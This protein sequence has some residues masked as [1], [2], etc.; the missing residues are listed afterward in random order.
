[1]ILTPEQAVEFGRELVSYYNEDYKNLV[2]VSD[3]N[4][5]L[6]ELKDENMQVA[7]NCASNKEAHR[8]F[9]SFIPEE[10]ILRTY[11]ELDLFYDDRYNSFFDLMENV[12]E[13]FTECDEGLER[14]INRVFKEQTTK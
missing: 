13:I 7:L 1:M 10:K 11:Y 2:V 9:F 12:Y 14:N 3:G 4:G 6:A 8:I 5:F